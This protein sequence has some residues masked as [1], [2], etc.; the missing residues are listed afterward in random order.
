[1]YINLKICTF[2]PPRVFSVYLTYSKLFVMC[3]IYFV[4]EEPKI[5]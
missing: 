1:M 4:K 2:L 5:L 3:N